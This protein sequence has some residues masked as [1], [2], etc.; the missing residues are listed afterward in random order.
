MRIFFSAD[1]FFVS[2]KSGPI[3]TLG[4][5]AVAIPCPVSNP[6]ASVTLVQW[7]DDTTVKPVP[8]AKYNSR[9]GF[10]V[11]GANLSGTFFCV[12]EFNGSTPQAVE[13]QVTN[14]SLTCTQRC[15]ANSACQV[16]NDQQVCECKPNFR[17]TFVSN[18]CILE[19]KTDKDCPFNMA[20]L[21][22]ESGSFLVDILTSIESRQE[23]TDDEQEIKRGEC[24]N[25]CIYK[26]SCSGTCQI[27]DHKPNCN[28][29]DRL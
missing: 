8:E 25:P 27:V 7:I 20:C 5:K 26:T 11:D 22:Q 17:Q 15:P 6:K 16:V 1:K 24:K 9:S 23:D 12:A 10:S 19:C 21:P 2:F 29:A 13:F 18:K 14:E 4:L 3:S 28:E